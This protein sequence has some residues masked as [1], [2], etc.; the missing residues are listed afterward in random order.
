MK[1]VLDGHGVHDAS[2]MMP[3]DVYHNLRL[4]KMNDYLTSVIQA[5]RGKILSDIIE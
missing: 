4:R 2:I 1:H 5:N 3:V